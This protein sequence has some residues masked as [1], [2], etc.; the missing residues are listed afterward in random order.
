[1]RTYSPPERL[2]TVA[3]LGVLFA[4][5]Q[6]ADQSL[7]FE[8]D[9]GEGATTTIGP[10]GGTVTVPPTF[11]LTFP[12]GSLPTSTAVQIVPRISGPFS[13]DAGA[14]VP[15]SAFDVAPAGT[16]LSEPARVEIAVDPLLLEAGDDVRLSVAVMRDDGSVAT[17]DATYDLTNGVLAAEIDELGPVAAVVSLDALSV[18][19]GAPPALGGGSFPQPT[20][21]APGGP[22]TAQFGGIEFLADCSPDARQ[23]FSSGLI[24]LWA[25]DVVRSRLGDDLWFLSPTV[26]ASLEFISFDAFGIPT[27]VFGAISVDGN[28]RARFNSAVTSVEMED[29]ASTGPG[30]TPQPT[31]LTVTGNVMVLDQTTTSSGSVEFNEQLAFGITGIGTSE[32]MTVEVEA[33][34]EFDNDDGSVEIGIVTAHIRLRVPQS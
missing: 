28:L 22:Q 30:S 9:E 24:R 31:G 20:P 13:S 19:L 16:P 14:P 27:Q 32:M 4:G 8:L 29:G 7:P 33:E 10:N 25:D 34:V 3:L 18:G 1:M 21:P 12:A 26:S 23:C 6:Q 5:C 15:G 11:S 2:W 17:F